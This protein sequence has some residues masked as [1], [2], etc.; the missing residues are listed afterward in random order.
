MALAG[1][2]ATVEVVGSDGLVERDPTAHTDIDQSLVATFPL[3]SSAGTQP[4]HHAGVT[5]RRG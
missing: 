3:E 2:T 5:R 4:G 1:V